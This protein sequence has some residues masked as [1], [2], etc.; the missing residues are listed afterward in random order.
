MKSL[1]QVALALGILL[2]VMVSS[3]SAQTTPTGSEIEP[4]AK[5][6][7]TPKVQQSPMKVRQANDAS[8][9]R[10]ILMSGAETIGKGNFSFN[11]Y[12]LVLAGFTYGMT[13]SSQIT[14]TTLMPIISEFPFLALVNGK[15]KVLENDR[16]ILSLQPEFTI[17]HYEGFTIG[18][19]GAGVIMDVRVDDHAKAIFT[20]SL[21]THFAFGEGFKEDGFAD[22]A[23]FILS[24]GFS[25]Q[26]SS[27]VKLKSELIFPSGYVWAGSANSFELY[28]EA[29][30]FNYGVRFYGKSLAVDLAFLLPVH[31]EAG[32]SIRDVLPMGYPYLTFSAKF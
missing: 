16:L 28:E 13:E 6:P 8:V 9:D 17:L 21:L 7:E 1:Q 2:A 11:S 26:V 24:V 22:A 29:I 25:Y 14:L 32:K 23:S 18:S 5:T 27:M 12:Q 3:A 31:P 10:N 15:F 4:K 20:T 30:L 19:V